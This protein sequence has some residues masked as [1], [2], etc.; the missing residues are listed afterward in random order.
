M[1]FNG[2]QDQAQFKFSD[3]VLIVPKTNYYT[4]L[5]PGHNV[6]L[7]IF[8]YQINLFRLLQTYIYLM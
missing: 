6:V 1:S 8:I 4:V 5:L 2:N 3:I 7:R